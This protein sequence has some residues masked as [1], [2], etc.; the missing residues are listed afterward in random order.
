SA[1]TSNTTSSTTSESVNFIDIGVKL[2]VTPTIHDDG[3]ITM[4]IKP[5]VSTASTSVTSAVTK[6]E[7]PIV[8]TSEVDTTVRVKDGVTIIIGGLIKDESQD[9]NNKIP[10]LGSIPFVGKV[11][12]HQEK[13]LAKTEIVIFLTPHIITGDIKDEPSAFA[14]DPSAH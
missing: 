12:S 10:L 3:Y 9:I 11:F 7:I 14:A 1:T 6:N 4:K 2:H 5:E 13:G 8:D